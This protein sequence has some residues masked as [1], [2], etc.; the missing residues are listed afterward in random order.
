MSSFSSSSSF[1]SISENKY[2]SLALS[3]NQ[4]CVFL[5]FSVSP[6]GRMEIKRRKL[7]CWRKNLMWRCTR[8]GRYCVFFA[9]HPFSSH[10]QKYFLWGIFTLL[11]LLTSK[12]TLPFWRFVILPSFLF[13]IILS[14]FLCARLRAPPPSLK[15]LAAPFSLCVL[16]ERARNHPL[17]TYVSIFSINSAAHILREQ[18]K[19]SNWPPKSK[20]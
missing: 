2:F 3:H 12:V 15:K 13:F 6:L 5:R 16:S 10:T 7:F 18:Y 8:G 14:V 19:N 4:S 9:F 20:W 17:S 1:L 11:L